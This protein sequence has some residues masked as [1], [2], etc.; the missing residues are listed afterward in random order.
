[1]I[2]WVR[3]DTPHIVYYSLHSHYDYALF[4]PQ[5]SLAIEVVTSKVG[6]GVRRPLRL[7]VGGV[8]QAPLAVD[9]GEVSRRMSLE[10]SLSWC[11]FG[12]AGEVS[13][14]V[15]LSW[16]VRGCSRGVAEGVAVRVPVCGCCRG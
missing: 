5:I 3:Y 9:N 10:V 2:Q 15:S 14:R 7:A 12:D 16:A 13:R 1:M 6:V 4:V 11:L 8:M